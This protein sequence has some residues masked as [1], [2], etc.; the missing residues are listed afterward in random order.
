MFRMSKRRMLIDE[1]FK[2]WTWDG[3]AEI[4]KSLF[5]QDR[6]L[7][8][9]IWEDGFIIFLF[10]RRR[11]WY[12]SDRRNENTNSDFIS[13]IILVNVLKC[14]QSLKCWNIHDLIRSRS[15]CGN[16]DH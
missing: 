6:S 2:R 9:W 5:H 16:D 3:K 4:Q 1:T 13:S 7:H 15:K 10:R 12:W 8:L 11:L 14:E